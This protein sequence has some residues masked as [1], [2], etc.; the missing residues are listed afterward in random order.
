MSFAFTQCYPTRSH[1]SMPVAPQPQET[2]SQSATLSEGAPKMIVLGA[3]GSGLAAAVLLARDHGMQ[4]EV[5]DSLSS[6][7]QDDLESYAIGINPRGMATLKRVDPS[8][9]KEIDVSTGMID[10]WM[11]MAPPMKKIARMESGTVMGT[12][13]G[14]VVQGL[15]KIATATPGIEIKLGHKLVSADVE[16]STL[17]FL[18]DGTQHVVDYSRSR[19]IDATGCWSKLR[20]A[21]A[22]ADPTFKVETWPWEIHFRNLFTS[23]PPV[24]G[25]TLKP[26]DHY[27]FTTAGIYCAVLTG[28]RWA[29]SLSVNK[30]L[31]ADG[32]WMLAD[33]PTPELVAK[34][35]AH[36]REHCPP[37]VSMI[38]E[39]E[40][41][42]FFTRRSFTG[43][44]VRVSRLNYGERVCFLG[45]AAHSTIPSTGEGMN[46]ALEDVRFLIDALGASPGG[47]SGPWFA[48]F[49]QRRLADVQAISSYAAYLLEGMKADPAERNRRTAT[50]VLSL[51]GQSMGLLGPTWND[52]TFGKLAVKMA[53][54]S[55][56]Y[57]EWQSQ[58]KK[59]QPWGNRLI[60]YFAKDGG[61][62]QVLAQRRAAKLAEA[63]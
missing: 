35:K 54:Y 41:T 3:G 19:L 63:T 59:V 20:T 22:A 43:Q 60:W 12:T 49:N 33:A 2:P 26:K 23:D 10:A 28:Q 48:T 55:E 25:H 62:K 46:A 4:V 34:L 47:A 8:L 53:P 13:R 56:V 21:V 17:T 15:H 9:E 11:I 6:V 14:S 24:G 40:Y 50:M 16:N 57:E 27:I 39:E 1:D 37:A 44:V 51:I 31:Q 52:K 5:Y 42:R 36:M 18:A 32:D 30:A 45:D 38:E 61:R 58:M 29:F 7:Q